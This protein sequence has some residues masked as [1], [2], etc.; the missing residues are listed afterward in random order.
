MRIY[1]AKYPPIRWNA[2]HL[3]KALVWDNIYLV[4][5]PLTGK[6]TR[7]RQMSTYSAKWPPIQWKAYSLGT[8][9]K[10]M[11]TYLAKCLPIQRNAHS[12]GKIT[13]MQWMSTYSKKCL[14][15]W[16]N[17]HSVVKA[18]VV[19]NECPPNRQNTHLFGKHTYELLEIFNKGS[20]WEF[21]IPIDIGSLSGACGLHMMQMALSSPTTN[22]LVQDL[23]PCPT[24]VALDSFLFSCYPKIVVRLLSGKNY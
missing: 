17:A 12:L 6:S 20:L 3:V 23:R 1:L 10:Q 14:P 19:H 2:L 15:I 13:R 7:M 24:V 21:T 8:S 18:L 9:L 4:K 11:S 22:Q 16:R 5:Y